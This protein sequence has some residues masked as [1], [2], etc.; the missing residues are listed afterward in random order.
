MVWDATE[1]RSGTHHKND[2]DSPLGKLP[3]VIAPAFSLHRQAVLVL[4]FAGVFQVVDYVTAVA[5]SS[6]AAPAFYL[7]LG[8]AIALVLWGGPRYWPVVFLCELVGAI[9]SYHRPLLS[10]CGLPGVLSVYVFYATGLYV[11]RRWW[12]IDASLS[13]VGDVG[14]MAL[15]FLI[16][17]MPTAIVGS[18]ALMGDG[19]ISRSALVK[20]TINWWESDAIAIVTLTPML[21]LYVM[22]WVSS[23]MR[24]GL[25]WN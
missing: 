7:P 9:V 10:W 19:V 25:S 16:A 11:V 20:T 5:Q 12:R 1:F 4:V 23:S 18:L 13:S 22:P 24:N 21:L 3:D 2:G 6:A 17:A 14:R 15:T 8:L